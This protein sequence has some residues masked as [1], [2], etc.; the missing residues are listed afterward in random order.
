[1]TTDY[2]T[3][4]VMAQAMIRNEI[5]GGTLARE[6]ISETVDRVLAI[7]PGWRESVDRDRL[8]RDLETRFDI[9]IGRE[10]T[11]E[12]AISQAKRAVQ[13][14]RVEAKI[15]DLMQSSG[16]DR[17]IMQEQFTPARAKQ[18]QVEAA[19]YAKIFEN[20]QA[21]EAGPRAGGDL[22]MIKLVMAEACEKW[23]EAS[24]M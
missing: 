5:D 3:V 15:Q 11:L 18:V 8:V 13:G 20:I 21:L 7:D 12:P 14:S 17:D 1:M 19:V 6:T 24:Q 4:L 16:V 2:E 9:W 23:M 10:T 22:A